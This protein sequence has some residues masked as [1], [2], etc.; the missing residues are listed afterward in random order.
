MEEI[1]RDMNFQTVGWFWD[2]YKREL[3]VMDPPYQRRSVWTQE[4]KDYFV[5]TVLHGY[6]APAL[7]LFR[8]TTPDGISQYSVVDGKQRLSALFDFASNLFPVS[9]NS[10]VATITRFRGN[11]FKDLPNELKTSFWNYR[12]A[13]EYLHSSNE[14]IINNIFDR[15]NR[16]VAKLT[17]QELRHARYSGEFISEV[18]KQSAWMFKKLPQGVPN[19]STQSRRQM[20]DDEFVAQLLILIE[21]GPKKDSQD[22]LDE[23]FALREQNWENKDS[24][25]TRF[26]D[27]IEYLARLGKTESGAAL[28]KSRL[29]NQADFFSLFGA[30]NE[31]MQNDEMLQIQNTVASLEEFVKI[32]DDPGKRSK[33]K[34]AKEYFDAARFSSNDTGPRRL[35]INII[36]AVL[37]GKTDI[38]GG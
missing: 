32:V 9:Q 5:D 3:L 37:L 2:L 26:Q 8:E 13:V 30:I 22:D 10:T 34:A 1:R 11:Y 38:L 33:I 15:I 29:R 31:I 20:K 16:N 24:T 14:E 25:I 7:F 28:L 6:P 35:R 19:I 23:A 18:Q 36:H 27:I 4:Y 17:P 12:F 21:A